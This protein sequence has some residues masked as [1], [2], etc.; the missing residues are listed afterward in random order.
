VVKKVEGVLIN[1]W[2]LNTI[3]PRLEKPETYNVI[4]RCRLYPQ[5]LKSTARDAAIQAYTVTTTFHRTLY[6]IKH[7]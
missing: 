1:F 2:C 7:I 3:I 6:D 4:G 5:Y